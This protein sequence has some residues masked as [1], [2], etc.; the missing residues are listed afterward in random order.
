MHQAGQAD[1]ACALCALKF[2]FGL[3]PSLFREIERY[4][5]VLFAGAGISTEGRYTHPN[6]LYQQLIFET[7]SEDNPSFPELVDRF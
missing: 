2:D 5:A 7:E 6:T 4:D 1:C 3:S